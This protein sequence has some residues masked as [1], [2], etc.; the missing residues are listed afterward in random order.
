MRKKAQYDKSTHSKNVL[1]KKQEEKKKRKKKDEKYKCS[2]EIIA[3]I[4]HVI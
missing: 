4:A 2:T 3:V 1:W